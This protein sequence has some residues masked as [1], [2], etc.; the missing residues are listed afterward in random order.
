MILLGKVKVIYEIQSRFCNLNVTKSQRNLNFSSTRKS[1]YLF[2]LAPR[3]FTYT[4]AQ[5]FFH[6]TVWKFKDLSITQILR[7]I[8]FEKFLKCIT[9][10]FALFRLL[11]F[12]HLINFT[13]QKM[14]NFIK[15][16]FRA[17][18]CGKVAD[19]ALQDSSKLISRKI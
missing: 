3:T 18:K 15:S 8:N 4:W 12:V 9:A 16:K 1:S 6:P 14:Y 11:I 2:R 7:E 17:S 10:F 13:L 5:K 19:F